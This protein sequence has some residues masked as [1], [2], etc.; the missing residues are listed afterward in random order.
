MCAVY[1]VESAEIALAACSEI[2]PDLILMDWMLEGMSGID[3]CK[4]LQSNIDS[5]EIPII[6]VTSNTNEAQ[7]EQCWDAGAV[8]FIGKPIVPKTLINRVKTHLKYKLQSDAL[9]RDSFIDGLTQI[10]NRRFFNIEIIR[11]LKQQARF[12][13]P[14]SMIMVDIDYFKEYNDT[15]GH[16]NGDETLKIIA[17]KL[18]NNLR[19]PLD[20]VFRY[21]GEEFAILLPNTELE[22]A[23]TIADKVVQA[24]NNLKLIHVKGISNRVTISAGVT[25]ADG[26]NCD[27][28]TLINNADIA[29]YSAKENGKNR[30]QSI[31]GKSD[32]ALN[33]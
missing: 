17:Q 32:C 20:L 2:K 13:Q 24:I 26:C 12:N 3:A 33:F 28:M 30:C 1:P 21:G 27:V 4:R 29:L 9:K 15:Y 16:L 23:I 25:V 31:K 8:D 18:K 11:L 10:Y 7:Q 5:T 19:R 14:L 22:G 6:F